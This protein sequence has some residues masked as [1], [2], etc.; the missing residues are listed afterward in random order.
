MSPQYYLLMTK[1]VIYV[2]SFHSFHLC[3]QGMWILFQNGK[4]TSLNTKI[5][6]LFGPWQSTWDTADEQYS[7]QCHVR[8]NVSK[9]QQEASWGQRRARMR[10]SP[11]QRRA[12]RSPKR[13]GSFVT[14]IKSIRFP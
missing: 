6:Q 8:E 2:F 7:L 3:A 13:L 4:S 1:N 5:F 10:K 14:I 9:M 12:R 11:G